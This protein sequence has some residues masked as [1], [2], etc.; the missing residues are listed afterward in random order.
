MYFF[1]GLKEFSS[2][3]GNT[4]DL[5]AFTEEILNG[6]VHFLYNVRYSCSRYNFEMSLL[7]YVPFVPTCLKLLRGYVLTCLNLLRAYV[8][9][10]L[11]F[12]R[13]YVP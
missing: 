13:A 11:E 2:T 4:K 10:C 12:L 3:G 1:H 9:T 6:K 8:P 5:V 7:N